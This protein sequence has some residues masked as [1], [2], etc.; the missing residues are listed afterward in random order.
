VYSS[1]QSKLYIVLYASGN[2]QYDIEVIFQDR[3]E[4]EGADIENK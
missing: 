4:E 2:K 1:T 3:E